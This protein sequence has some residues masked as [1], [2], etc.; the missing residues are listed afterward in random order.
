MPASHR[1]P[2]N[3]PAA[4]SPLNEESISDEENDLSTEIETV[5]A[6]VVPPGT[7]PPERRAALVKRL[8]QVVRVHS[9]P[10]PPP[11]DFAGYEDVLKGCAG[12]ILEMAESNQRHIQAMEAAS[13]RAESRNST[14][15]LS[16]GFSTTLGLLICAIITA[17][18]QMPWLA[19]VFVGATGLGLVRSLLKDWRATAHTTQPTSKRTVPAPSRPQRRKR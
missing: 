9:G 2:D 3:L 15:A 16:Y 5:V 18:W 13:M 12:R 7:V 10:L 11:E 1:D 17:Y 4:P 8:T 19:S 14:L 6:E